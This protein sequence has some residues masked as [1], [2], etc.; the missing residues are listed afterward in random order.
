MNPFRLR[1]QG[2][3]LKLL[4]QWI[5]R[6]SV[7]FAIVVYLLRGSDLRAVATVLARAGSGHFAVAFL[8]YL[9]SHVVSVYRW[10]LIGRAVGFRNPVRDF[11]VFYFIG[12]FLNF[13]SP[14]LI[15]GDIGRGLYLAGDERK[16]SR[17]F[18]SVIVDRLIGLFG[19]LIFAG[20]TLLLLG[21]SYPLPRFLLYIVPGLAGAL[22]LIWWGLPRLCRMLSPEHR[23]RRFVAD[24]LASVSNNHGLLVKTLSISLLL[25]LIQVMVVFVLSLAA[26]I[27]LPFSYFLVCAPVVNLLSSLPI[28]VN[29]IGVR[30]SG[31]VFFLG[32]M[33]TSR[34]LALGLSFL[35][36]GVVVLSALLGGIC[37]L[38][39]PRLKRQSNLS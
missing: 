21:G 11:F 26:G 24:H 13:F 34:E 15:L 38:L 39:W 4:P 37:F 1:R 30:D 16:K 32:M 6:I 20:V 25:H 27:R 22:Y 23:L 8:L 33:G 36:L 14:S 35:W 28:S 12:V 5:L 3:F 9:L 31:Y 10:R 18:Q 17:A 7:S 2:F 19:L 29:G